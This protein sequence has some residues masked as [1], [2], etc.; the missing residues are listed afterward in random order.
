MRASPRG[1]FTSVNFTHSAPSPE[2]NQSFP[3]EP[4]KVMTVFG[5]RP[6]TIKMAPV[7]HAL[8]ANP[9]IDGIVCVTAQ[10]REMLDDL[11]ELFA[12]RPHYD[13]DIMTED[14][15]LTEVTTR[16]LQGME[17]VLE[18]ARPDVVLVHGDTTTSTS[19]ALAAFYRHVS[20]SGTS[21]PACARAIAGCRIRRR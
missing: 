6:D 1:S 15:T 18:E 7:V 8:A 13:L 12:I 11:L 17:P 3:S 9:E 2:L 4:L 10:H 20:R 14:Q 21:R 5:T 19:A 16:V